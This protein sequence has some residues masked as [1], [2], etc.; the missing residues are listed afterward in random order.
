MYGISNATDLGEC[1]ADLG[2][3]SCDT[4]SSPLLP[5]PRWFLPVL[6]WRARLGK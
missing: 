3:A 2:A 4:G 5:T 1:A 6:V